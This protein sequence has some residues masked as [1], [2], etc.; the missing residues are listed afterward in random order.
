MCEGILHLGWIGRDNDG[1]M[2]QVDVNSIGCNVDP[3]DGG[4]RIGVANE[5]E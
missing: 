4:A 5:D 1:I 2:F 3:K